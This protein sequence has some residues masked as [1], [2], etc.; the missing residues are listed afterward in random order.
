MSEGS[1]LTARLKFDEESFFS[2]RWRPPSYL[3]LFREMGG[4]HFILLLSRES[5]SDGEREREREREGK[6]V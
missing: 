1:G 3:H 5:T 4:G 2:K 6:S